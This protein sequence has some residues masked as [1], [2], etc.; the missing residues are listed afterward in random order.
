LDNIEQLKE[1]KNDL[2]PLMELESSLKSNPYDSPQS[3]QINSI[4]SL[5]ANDN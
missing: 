1:Y 5:Y 2:T 4:K 3:N